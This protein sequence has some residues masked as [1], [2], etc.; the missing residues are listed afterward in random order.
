[1]AAINPYLVFNGNCEE[2]FLFYKSVFGGEFPYI[3]KFKD[4]P[5]AEGNPALSEADGNKIMHVSLPIGDGSV[6]MGSD[7]NSASGEVT[8]GQNISISI[9]TKS[10]EE[11][12]KLF[13]GLSAGGTVTMP[14]SQTFWGAY[15]GMFADKFGI[16]WMVNFDENE[17]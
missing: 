5:P 7:S 12:D 4:M 17:K 11:A 16:S 9:N 6:L 13:N 8:F 15:F 1:M 3:G 2:A 14:M 10:K